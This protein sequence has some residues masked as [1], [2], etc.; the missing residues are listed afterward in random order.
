MN[1]FTIGSFV[2]G[3]SYLYKLDP[4]VK[5]FSVIL[6]MVGV[7]FIKNFYVLLGALGFVL[8]IFV[9]GRLSLIKAI[10]GLRHIIVLSIFIFIFQVIFNKT[11]EVLYEE[12]LH[13][14]I[15][16]IGLIVATLAFYL[17]INRFIKLKS[18]S[19]IVFIAAIYVILRYVPGLPKDFATYNLLVYDKG[20]NMAVFVL[21]RIVILMFIALLLTLTT[22]PDDLTLGMK[23]FLYP[24]K[25]IKVNPEEIA[26]I[27]TIALRYIPTIVVESKKIMDAQA[28]R[29]A[30]FNESNIFKK[31]GQIVSLL[32]P[33]F[34]ISFEKSD[35]LADAMLSRNFVPGRPKTKYH[36]LKFKTIDLIAFIFVLLLFG[37]IIC[38]YILL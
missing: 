5:L 11:G 18:L 38:Q 16:S 28:S 21:I 34:V 14:S 24:L 25:V 1:N 8:L 32:V 17:F 36:S 13:F 6:L 31:I 20:L 27:I 9:S 4:R 12:T 2:P 37:G 10:L 23:W 30:D 15:L 7:F 3:K 35:E 29:G 22:K 33:M 26:L 19:L